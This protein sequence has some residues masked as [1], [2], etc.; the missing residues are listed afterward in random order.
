MK[1]FKSNVTNYYD[2]NRH[3]NEAVEGLVQSIFQHQDVDK[4]GYVNS[5]SSSPFAVDLSPIANS[6]GPTENESAQDNLGRYDISGL[7]EY[8]RRICSR[9][10]EGGYR[11]LVLRGDLGSGKSASINHVSDVLRHPLTSSCG[12]C[13]QC[14]PVIIKMDFNMGY[15]DHELDKLL[16]EFRRQLYDQLRQQLRE[17][18]RK[19]DLVNALREEAIRPNQD[20][21]AFGRF[22]QDYENPIAWDD[23]PKNVR[24]DR[25][26][27]YVDTETNNG[28]ENLKVLMWL[29]R[30][31]KDSLQ[32]EP[33]CLILIFDNIDSVQ[34]EAQFQIL[35]EILACQAVAKVQ[36][37]V[38]LRRG[39]HAKYEAGGASYA[40]GTIDHAG[41]D[42]KEVIVRRLSHYAERWDSLP[43]VKAIKNPGYK[44][45]IKDRLDYLIQTK[46]DPRGG[47][48]RVPS[49]CGSS[50]R[51]G[52]YLCERFF[53]N[54]AIAYNETP[55][56]KD[57][58]VRAT[59]FGD[60]TINEISPDDDCIANLLLNSLTGE[61]SLLNIRVLQLVA[62]FKND[63]S[64]RTVRS[65][66]GILK[67]IGGWQ[68]DEI[69]ESFNYLLF[70]RR[71]L[72]WVD[73]RTRYEGIAKKDLRDVLHLTEAGHFYLNKLLLDLT[74]VQEAALSVRWNNRHIPLSVDYSQVVERFGILRSCLGVLIKKDYDQTNNLMQWLAKDGA[75]IPI[76]PILFINRIIAALGKSAINILMPRTQG[77]E[78][79]RQLEAIEELRGWNS[80][81]EIWLGTEQELLGKAHHR[82]ELLSREY[83]EKVPLPNDSKKG[84]GSLGL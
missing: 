42:I 30:L 10:L 58:I 3:F 54:S 37:L 2:R 66:I 70:L 67:A 26:F 57:D 22:A 82:L 43:E 46:D 15:H 60:S 69:T 41:P 44:Q 23:I 39:T 56:F 36:A 16:R 35:V 71:P 50:I 1:V 28:T 49:I 48:Q 47:I 83:R 84:T 27:S 81:I 25:L 32:A 79:G 21:A 45:A 14:A 20:Y 62:E 13:K 40:F 24:V 72:I 6:E 9:V 77:N 31:A 64:S 78:D 29:V 74:Y 11:T 61:A 19:T 8:E 18:F 73:G 51:L 68:E 76:R 34:P 5:R 52:L 53:L 17:L 33:G 80:M 38:T 55:W 12:L 75:G 7:G 59:L 4:T 63:E 65:L